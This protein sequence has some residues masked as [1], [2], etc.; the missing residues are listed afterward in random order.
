M[1]W[2]DLRS[3]VEDIYGRFV[4][5]D[6]GLDGAEF[7]VSDEASGSAREPAVAF[8]PINGTYLVV[9]TDNRLGESRVYGQRLGSAGTPTGTATDSN[10]LILE[11]PTGEL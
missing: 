8:D 5:P 9:F 2:T 7:V 4:D 10:F 3:G 11:R 6:G 1:V